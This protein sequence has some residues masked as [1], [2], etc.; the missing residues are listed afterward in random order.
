[1]KVEYI[2]DR[3]PLSPMQRGMLFHS[4]SGHTP[5]VDIEQVFCLLHE[6][7]DAAAL[8]RAWQRV[9]ERHEVLRTTFHWEGVAKP[10]QEVHSDVRL[11]VE[12]HDWRTMSAGGDKVG[13]RNGSGRI[14]SAGLI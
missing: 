7:L 6:E 13:S 11:A 8:E 1:M 4:I 5:G 9:L 2:A 12:G 3:Y 14:G 10:E